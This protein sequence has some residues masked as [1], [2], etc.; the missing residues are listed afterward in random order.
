MKK[1]IVSLLSV[2]ILIMFIPSI[3]VYASDYNYEEYEDY[4]DGNTE[5]VY[6]WV[7]EGDARFC[8]INNGGWSEA[9]MLV[10]WH[11]ID[12]ETYYFY[13][14]EMVDARYGQMATGEVWIGDWTF[15]F[16]EEGHLYDWKQGLE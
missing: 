7:Q 13:S 16:D 2:F 6:T 1:V 3:N 11:T 4:T 9:D 5:Q 15:Y 8:Y 14:Q 12:G 10:G